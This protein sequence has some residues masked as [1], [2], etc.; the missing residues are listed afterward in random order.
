[1]LMLVAGLV[2]GIGSL[3]TATTGVF[4]QT[5]NG[6]LR[7]VF[8]PRFGQ[9]KATFSGLAGAEKRREYICMSETTR[10]IGREQH[11]GWTKISFLCL[12]ALL[13]AAD[14]LTTNA[15]LRA[16]DTFEGNPF[17]R[18]WQ[19]ALGEFWWVP[20]LLFLPAIKY[21]LARYRRLWPAVLIVTLYAIVIVN[22]LVVIAL[23]H[24]P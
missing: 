1:L 9:N 5:T 20:K 7:F 10:F 19:A 4:S 6:I 12:A 11:L 24:Q 13:Q 22:N 2:I 18:G 16:A 23:A 8:L 3:N 15:F 21:I 17:V 14:V